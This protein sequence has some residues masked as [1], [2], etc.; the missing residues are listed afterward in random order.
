MKKHTITF[1]LAAAITAAAVS[2]FAYSES[3]SETAREY[4]IL[5]GDENGN[6]NLS[7]PVTRAEMA[8]ILCSAMRLSPSDKDSGLTD[9]SSHWAKKYINA[10]VENGLLNGF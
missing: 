6:L 4:K 1:I 7:S 3:V 2:A 5:E 8:K 9:I 10:A